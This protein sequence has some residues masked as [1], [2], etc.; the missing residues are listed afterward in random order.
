MDDITLSVIMITFNHEK[1]LSE[2]IEGVLNQK[3]NFKY[4]L[5]I[6][7]DASKDN[8]QKLI[9]DFYLK[10]PTKIV[11]ILREQNIGANKNWYEAYLKARGKYIA[12]CEGDDFWLSNHKLQVQVDFL[13]A[14]IGYSLVFHD[15][16]V[17][18]DV[19]QESYVGFKQDDY[20]S[21]DIASGCV[22]IPSLSVVFRKPN[23]NLPIFFETNV[24]GDFPLFLEISMYGKVRYINEIMGARRVHNCGIWSSLDEN[25][26]LEVMLRTLYL[27]IGSYSIEINNALVNYHLRL[28]AKSLNKG[29]LPPIYPPELIAISK[30]NMF[31]LRIKTILKKLR[32]FNFVNLLFQK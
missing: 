24:I 19:R 17:V 7:D 13:E 16:K 8:S 3:V 20:S 1:F 5:I 4:E 2:S 28:I 15:V 30:R 23:L 11:P 9:Q 10:N 6:S 21:V 14:N 29:Y 18:G 22:Q 12:L 25:A 31:L 27:M 32:I 26:R